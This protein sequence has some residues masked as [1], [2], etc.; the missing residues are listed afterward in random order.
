VVVSV[1][2]GSVAAVVPI[3]D[4]LVGPVFTLDCLKP[5]ERFTGRTARAR[6]ETLC[7]PGGVV[8]FA[9]V[10]DHR[11]SWWARIFATFGYQPYDLI[12]DR[13]WWD[14]RIDW[15][16]RQNLILF[17]TDEEARKRGWST[18]KRSL[19]L[20]QPALLMPELRPRLAATVCIPWRPTPSRQAA[21]DRV[22]RFWAMFGWPMVTADSETPIFS[23]SQ[24]RNNAVRKA[25][26]SVVIIADADTLIDPLNVL[27]SVADPGG[28]WWP[29]NQYRILSTDYLNTP[30]AALVNAPYMTAWDGAGVLGVGGC[31]ITTQEE[32]WRL[33][34]QPPE[35]IGWGWEDT[36]FTMIVSTL[37]RARRLTGHAYAF[38]HNQN[39]QVYHG[40]IADSEGW[41]RDRSRNAGLIDIYRVAQGRP[42][43]MREIIRQ[44]D[45]PQS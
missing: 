19:N 5:G 18:P 32:Y 37:S 10:G 38:E 13:I 33:G 35:F 41:S 2:E 17:A 1:S 28:V 7:R 14:Q 42:W 6:V 16:I 39:A 24:A 11:P 25:T 36:A 27:R 15:P 3:L 21:F 26:T 40:A 20:A 23:L 45:T 31:L 44:R 34:G 4:E 43:L 8:A 22:Q 9:T 12:R 29:F 30:M